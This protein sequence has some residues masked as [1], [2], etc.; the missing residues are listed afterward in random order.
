MTPEGV[1]LAK[2]DRAGHVLKIKSQLG[3]MRENASI[4]AEARRAEGLPEIT[5][6]GFLIRVPEGTDV[7]ALA[8]SL[9]IELVAET[10]SG[11]MFA[12]S[13]SLDF[14][15]LEQV[16]AQFEINVIGGGVAATI[17]DVFHEKDDERKLA[18][19]LIGRIHDLWPFEDGT[20]YTF[21]LG[22]Q[23]A[24]SSKK[25]EWTRLPP[26]RRGQTKE[27]RDKQVSIVRGAD[28]IKAEE[29][30]ADSA[31]E[32]F[33]DL[34]SLISYYG[35]EVVDGLKHNDL[36]ETR[37]SISFPDSI[38][39]RVR[40]SGKGFRDLIENYRHLFEVTMPPDVR[41][42]P[43][44]SET[45]GEEG[46]LNILPPSDDAPKVCVIDSGIQEEHRW[47]EPAIDKP[48]SLCFLPE[49]EPND[50]AD[51]FSPRGHGTRVAGAVLYPREVPREGEIQPIAWIQNARVLD[52]ENH[53]PETLP[54]ER[55]LT[56]IVAH[57]GVGEQ[58]TKIFNHSISDS[59]PCG[60]KRMCSWAAKIDDLVH[61]YDLLFVQI[62]GNIGTGEIF[63]K[64][65][66]GG[67]H[68]SQLL[69][70][71]AKVASPGQSLHALNV[72]SISHAV[73]D[74]HPHQSFARHTD[75]PS[76]FTR[77]GY[78]PLWNVVKPEVVEYG[79]DRLCESP[80]AGA[81]LPPRSAH[82]N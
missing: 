25:V 4:D 22:I 13:D 80:L 32:R 1:R 11:L 7:D 28:R 18:E 52:A 63:G 6:K 54:P 51:Y 10:E 8:Y 78:S 12:A 15:R 62:V 56:D 49:C 66:G 42:L 36:R 77:S 70:D 79:E 48:S 21:D 19:L 67:S 27:N 55:Y 39:V 61:R 38:E 24:G 37:K 30:W 60:N 58:G 34:Q 16:L 59:K 81:C 72:G 46:D 71:N 43:G 47:L 33:S 26:R 57:F 76:A 31:D 50:V 73:I 45:E 82:R 3:S 75:F 5:G 65:S 14:D 17:F 53:L 20:I 35:G 9:G 64:L 68:P 23:T 40:M 41:Y 69:D 29:Q 74:G 2:D 44:S